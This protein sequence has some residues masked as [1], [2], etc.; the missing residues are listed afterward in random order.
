MTTALFL[1]SKQGDTLP[2]RLSD[3]VKV[4]PKMFTGEQVLNMEVTITSFIFTTFG[5]TTLAF[6]YR[7]ANCISFELT[8]CL[9]DFCKLLT[10]KEMTRW[11]ELY[12][13]FVR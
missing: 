9:A 13:I 1:A 12:T 11:S 8:I 6:A 4:F 2:L 3:A 7:S 10:W 5:P